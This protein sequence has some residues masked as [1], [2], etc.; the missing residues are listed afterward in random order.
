LSISPSPLPPAT[1]TRFDPRARGPLAGS[2]S[3]CWAERVLHAMSAALI[4]MARA[5]RACCALCAPHASTRGEVGA[6][7]RSRIT[8][9]GH[10][11]LLLCR[12]THA[13]AA[14]ACVSAPPRRALTEQR[15]ASRASMRGGAPSVRRRTAAA[16]LCA[17]SQSARRQIILLRV[18][19][20]RARARADARQDTAALPDRTRGGQKRGRR[21][22]RQRRRRCHDASPPHRVPPAAAVRRCVP[23]CIWR[24]ELGCRFVSRGRVHGV[25]SRPLLMAAVRMPAAPSMPRARASPAHARVCVCLRT[26]CACLRVC[27][28]RETCAV[29]RH[30]ST[31]HMRCGL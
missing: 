22:R 11:A 24:H 17:P 6:S 14:Q 23:P 21:G 5:P 27:G 3:V 20:T 26:Q 4:A 1:P 13:L 16:A 25:R 8:R 2:R 7:A 31:S 9:T 30:V 28:A 10:R 15:R 29:S 12:R 18:F 19:A